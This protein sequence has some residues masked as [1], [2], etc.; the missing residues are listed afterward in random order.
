M[1]GA[2]QDAGAGK[3]IGEKTFGK[4]SVQLPNML[5]D[6]SQLRV[7]IAHWFT[8]KNRAIDGVGLEPDIS[9]P[10]TDGRPRCQARSR[11]WTVQRSTC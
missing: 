6:G 9:V 2:I 3:L 4:G 7:T 1:A 8:P 5:S 11:N 10:L